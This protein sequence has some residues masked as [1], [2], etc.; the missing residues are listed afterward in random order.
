VQLYVNYFYIV[1]QTTAHIWNVYTAHM[2]VM[3]FVNGQVVRVTLALNED[4]HVPHIQIF[5]FE[6]LTRTLSL[7]IGNFELTF[8]LSV[9]V[10]SVSYSQP[11]PIHFNFI[12][13]LIS[14]LLQ[15]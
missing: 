12:S 2:G 3:D 10:N 15:T 14:F 11:S 8:S 5:L 7:F 13:I 1:L 4:Q 9:S 6:L